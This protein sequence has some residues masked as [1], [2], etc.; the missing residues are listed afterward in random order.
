MTP[1]FVHKQARV[2][3]HTGRLVL[4]P[5]GHGP[6][7]DHVFAWAREG[8]EPFGSSPAKSIAW[9]LGLRRAGG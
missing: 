9:L 8:S 3:T 4:V 6:L 2:K 7:G 1:A 5:S